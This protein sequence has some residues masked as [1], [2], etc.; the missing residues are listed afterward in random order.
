MKGCCSFNTSPSGRLLGV[1]EFGQIFKNSVVRKTY[2]KSADFAVVIFQE[3]VFAG[4][5]VGIEKL[6]HFNSG[7]AP[8]LLV[9]LAL[10][11]V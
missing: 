5:R 2:L 3:G 11:R 7:D 4:H 9:T 1:F 8:L 10:K 6:T